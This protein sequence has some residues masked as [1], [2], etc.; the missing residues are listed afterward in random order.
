[1]KIGELKIQIFLFRGPK[2]QKGEKGTSVI[3]TRFGRPL[4]TENLSDEIDRRLSN[5]NDLDLM[6][7]LQSIARRI[8]PEFC[9]HD[10]SE[11]PLNPP[12]TTPTTTTD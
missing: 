1:M 7:V 8:L 2:G 12:T 10:C 6:P 4:L 9:E 3:E 5:F 11:P